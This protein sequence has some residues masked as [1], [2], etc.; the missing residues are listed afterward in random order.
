MTADG[1]RDAALRD[2][3]SQFQASVVSTGTYSV[4]IYGA[5]ATVRRR[6]DS[7]IVV[8]ADIQGARRERSEFVCGR[9]FARYVLD[10]RP[11]D[12]RLANLLR[13]RWPDAAFTLEG[14]SRLLASPIGRD[15]AATLNAAGPPQR[16]RVGLEWTTGRWILRAGSEAV[17]LRPHDLHRTFGTTRHVGNL[18]LRLL[19]ESRSF[20]I[21]RLHDRD[22]FWLVAEGAPPGRLLTFFNVYPDGRV[23]VLAE[24][25]PSSG[26]LQIP[27]RGLPCADNDAFRIRAEPGG[28]EIYLVVSSKKRLETSRFVVLPRRGLVPA[29]ASN[30]HGLG[31]LLEWLDNPQIDGVATLEVLVSVSHAD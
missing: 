31:E 10:L 3:A 23:G 22:L 8:R 30:A 7:S 16:I 25:C 15:L 29:G 28:R 11:A 19:T 27:T 9:H 2:M 26:R 12:L 18:V 21:N 6:Q 20:N 1:A 5:H 13:R 4:S 14:P 24:A 17:A